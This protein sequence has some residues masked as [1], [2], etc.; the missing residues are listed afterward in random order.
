MQ[1]LGVVAGGHEQR[2]RGVDAHAIDPEQLGCGVLEQW[3]D[4]GVEVGDLPSRS[5][6]RWASE[7]SDALVAAVTTSGERV[8]RSP[9]AA[10]TNSVIGRPLRRLCSWSGALKVSWRI[11]VSALMRAPRAERLA[12]TRT[13]TASTEPSRLLAVP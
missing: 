5:A 9:W 4:H 10:A 11:W 6:T 8:G 13:R 3:G 7:E 12:T 2:G 1:A